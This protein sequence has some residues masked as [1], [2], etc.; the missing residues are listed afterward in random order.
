MTRGIEMK[1]T[2]ALVAGLTLVAVAGPLPAAAQQ[3]SSVALA[4][5]EVA[6]QISASASVTS[7][8]D[9]ITITIPVSASGATAAVARAVNQVTIDW[10]KTALVAQGVDAGAISLLPSGQGA[11]G[12]PGMGEETAGGVAAG[13][14]KTARTVVQVELRDAAQL[15]RVTELLEQRNQQMSAPVYALRDDS[16]ARGTATAEAIR[17]AQ[18]QAESSA[19]AMGYRVVRMTRLSNYGQALFDNGDFASMAQ[20]MF[21]SRGGNGGTVLTQARVW[22]DFVMKPR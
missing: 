1:S 5:G 18:A 14:K 13:A 21:A 9:K 12:F 6:L 19:A 4:P 17:K 20:T 11:F 22:I 2:I 16:A 3:A 15:A 8:A 7:P 10:L